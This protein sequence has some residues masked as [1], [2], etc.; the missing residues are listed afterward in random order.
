MKSLHNNKLQSAAVF[1]LLFAIASAASAAPGTAGGLTTAQGTA[2][3]IQTALFGF[4][5]ACAGSYLLYTGIMAW[6][7]KKTW[8]DFGMAVVYVSLVGSAIALANWAWVLF[9]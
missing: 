5:G 1:A 6:S 8:G 4:V 3:A 2:A 9:Q 7:D